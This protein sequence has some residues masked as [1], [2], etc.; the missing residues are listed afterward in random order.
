MIDF[1]LYVQSTYSMNG[2][3]VDIDKLVV[4]AKKQGYETLALVDQ[5]HMYGALKFYKKCLETGIKPIIGLQVSLESGFLGSIELLLLAKNYNGYR[6]LIQLSSK[7]SFDSVIQL[8]DLKTY[9]S[10][11]VVVLKTDEGIVSKKL[12]SGDTDD[13]QKLI[14]ELQSITKSFYLG[15]DLNDYQFELQAAPKL[16]GLGP[17]LVMNRVKYYKK[18]DVKTSTV[19]SKILRESNDDIG[20]FSNQETYYDLKSTSQLDSM[21]SQYT[22]AIKNSF[23]MI[24]TC[25]LNIDLSERH[26]PKFPLKSGS[27]YDKLVELSNKGLKRR[28]VQSNLYKSQF[29]AY[30]KRLDYELSIIHEM[31][32]EDYFLIVWDFV[33]YA[34]KN[35][36]LVG[37]GRGSAAGSLVAY[38]LGIVDVDPIENDLY[39]ERFLNPE[40]ITMPD[41]DMDFPDDKREEVIRY[42]IDKYGKE[43]VVSIITFGTFQGKSAIRDAGRILEVDSVIVDELSKSLSNA[44]NSLEVFKQKYKKEYSYYM[45]IPEIKELISIADQL[46]GLVKHVSTHAAGI[47]I[48]GED[49]REHCAI[50]PGLMDAYQT[51][52]EASDLEAL[53]LLKFDF[54]GLRNLT[55]IKDTMDLIENTEGRSINIYKIPMDDLPTF[56][57]LKRVQTL[58]VFQLESRGMMDLV[59]K[60]QID[61]FADIATCISLFRPGPMENIPTFLKRRNN[62]ERIT[63]PHVDLLPILKPTNGIIIYQ[64]QIMTIA[65]KFAGYSLGEADVLRRAVSKKK[66]E[67]L[68]SERKRF[69]QGAKNQ[70]YAESV[71]NTIYDYIVKFANYGFNK[72]H[73]VAYALVGYWMAYLKA[74]YGKYF[75]SVLLNSQIGSVFGTKTYIMEAKQLGIN[76]LPPRINK[77]GVDYVPENGNLRFPIKGIKGIGP[78]AAEQII[79]IQDEQPIKDLVDFVKRKRDVHSNVIE[80][81]IFAG[82]FD[83]FKQNK[84]TMIEN[85]P[86]LI[87][88]VEFEYKNE[89]FHFLEYEEY[90]YEILHEK[91]KELLGLNFQ[92]HILNKYEEVIKKNKYMLVSDVLE[93]L[94]ENVYFIGVIS[95]IKQI[96]TKKQEEMAFIEVEDIF[97]NVDTTFFPR[98]YSLYKTKLKKGEVFLFSG[99]KEIRNNKLQVI[100]KEIHEM[101]E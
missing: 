39:F 32:Y 88:F 49:I 85:L 24:D 26:L 47:I 45:N 66:R 55:I 31:G 42:V 3:L 50:Q 41:I 25:N 9:H 38:V 37:P 57:L 79:S 16:K 65:N 56:E 33:L 67:V 21:Y 12:F 60:M 95:R 71:A 69:V 52:Y 93:S 6:N 84:R 29:E 78:I 97:Q 13:L 59:G 62:E 1:N 63:Y 4:D 92:Y 51:Q 73:A 64:E 23:E 40:R 99:T 81:L 22:Q 5:V 54:L 68:E 10:D 48:S 61:N 14:K 74:N 27:V 8:S 30:K 87:S 98:T 76:I 53:G 70:G 44:N 19:L 77:S 20:L 96:T 28:L 91:E 11:L 15:L 58:G 34:K 46:S 43:K 86:K 83:D 18:S 72:S 89:T 82:V 7:A 80:A 75:M 100:I 94:K 35:G 2:S 101:K 90:E 17:Q 36:I